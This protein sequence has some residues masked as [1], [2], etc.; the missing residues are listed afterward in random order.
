MPTTLYERFWKKV[1]ITDGCWRWIG[2]RSRG[3]GY[4]YLDEQR[5]QTLAH[6][7]AYEMLVGLIP[8]GAEIDHVCHNGDAS[9]ANGRQCLHRR[10]V[11]PD[12]LE[13][14]THQVNVTRG[15][16]D[17]N[18][19]K[20]HC[21]FGHAFDEKNTRW[22]VSKTTGNRVRYCRACNAVRVKRY[23]DAGYYK[24]EKIQ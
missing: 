12:H 1:E 21:K 2:A 20:T 7:V 16:A 9:C 23:I 22:K 11:N 13:P 19:N 4:I 3:Y 24:R 17:F 15:N 5:G 6:R 10:C 18:K 14:V 8:E